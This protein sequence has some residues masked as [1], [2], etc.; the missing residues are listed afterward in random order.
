MNLE[1]SSVGNFSKVYLRAK[2][3]S[4]M[5]TERDI[6]ER[7]EIGKRMD[8]EYST[9]TLLTKETLLMTKLLGK[10]LYDCQKPRSNLF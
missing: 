1:T 2:E 8:M 10:E 6:E 9:K 3:L 5:P 7:S 4:N